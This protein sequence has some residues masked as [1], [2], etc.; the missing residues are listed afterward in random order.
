M[1]CGLDLLIWTQMTLGPSFPT[2]FYGL[3]LVNKGSYYETIGTLGCPVVPLIPVFFFF[4][5][6]GGGGGGLGSLTHPFKQK[7]APLF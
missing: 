3:Y 5:F 7:R 2:V 1:C 4:F 6:G